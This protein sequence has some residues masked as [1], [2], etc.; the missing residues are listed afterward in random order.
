MRNLQ[1]R[2]DKCLTQH[3]FPLWQNQAQTRK[4]GLDVPL[5]RK[6]G[7]DNGEDTKCPDDDDGESL[8]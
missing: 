6:C 8:F 3:V 5:V 1:L 7:G 2:E 4:V